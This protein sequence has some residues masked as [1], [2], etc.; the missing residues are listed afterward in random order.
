MGKDR[1]RDLATD[2]QRIYWS[3]VDGLRMF[4]VANSTLTEL[5]AAATTLGTQINGV[6][7]D[8]AGALYVTQ[9]SSVLRCAMVAGQCTFT[10]LAITAG[11]AVDIAV[12]ATHIYWGTTD[13]SIW[14]LRKP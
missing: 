1:F 12:D 2:G 11:T 4:T 13:G 9:Q 8:A 6:A 7:V 14:R 5:I 3:T 10:T